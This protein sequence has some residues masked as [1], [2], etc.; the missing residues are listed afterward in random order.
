[1]IKAGHNQPKEHKI[2]CPQCKR[3]TRLRYYDD[4]VI[5]R[6]PLYCPKCK[7][8]TRI[9][10]IDNKIYKSLEPDISNK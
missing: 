6:F 10:L 4:T 7:Q 3:T 1:M 8:E 2:H 9:D 5:L